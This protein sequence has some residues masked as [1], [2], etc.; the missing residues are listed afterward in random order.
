[1]VYIIQHT[2]EC[3]HSRQADMFVVDV[4]VINHN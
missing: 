2:A 3:E 4:D 1:M